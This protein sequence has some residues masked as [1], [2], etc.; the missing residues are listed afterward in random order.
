MGKRAKA[1]TSLE[2]L[3]RMA[4][5]LLRE[6]E[7]HCPRTGPGAKPVVPDWLIGTLI[8]VSIL[9]RKKSKAAQFRFLA[10]EDNRQRLV[11]ALERDE[12]LSRSGWYRRYRRAHEL[13]GLPQAGG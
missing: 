9:N 4:I 3:V 2:A 12:F 8:M 11:A 1:G 6:A 7:R 10:D 13:S 5:L